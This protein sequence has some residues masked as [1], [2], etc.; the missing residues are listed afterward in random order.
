VRGVAGT[1]TIPANRKCS[2]CKCRWNQRGSEFCATCKPKSQYMEK[3][4]N[5]RQDIQ[6]V[7][8]HARHEGALS[9][10]PEISV[11]AV[12][13]QN[14]L[15]LLL[16]IIRATAQLPQE[17]PGDPMPLIEEGDHSVHACY[18]NGPYGLRPAIICGCGWSGT[19][20]TWRDVGDA[21]DDHLKFAR[22]GPR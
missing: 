7:I 3:V 6:R 5:A 22:G 10:D 9:N 8:N 12:Q 20:D 13:A 19:E 2:R 11:R 17:S 21:Y 4:L 15:D 14:G 18:S 1:G 16:E